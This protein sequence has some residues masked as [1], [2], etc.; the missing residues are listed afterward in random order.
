M[1]VG[2]RVAGS[3]PLGHRHVSLSQALA[4]KTDTRHSALSFFHQR[5][6]G[7][8]HLFRGDNFLTSA[9]DFL[10]QFLFYFLNRLRK[11][12][13]QALEY[14]AV[15]LIFLGRKSAKADADVIWL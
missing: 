12:F 1:R 5:R 2:A 3:S 14:Q 15:N 6:A 4:S 7:G 8:H 10:A 9:G 13:S 11:E